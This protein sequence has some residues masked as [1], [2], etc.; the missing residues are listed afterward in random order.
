MALCR[1]EIIHR[2][3][4]AGLVDGEEVFPMGQLLKAFAAGHPDFDYNLFFGNGLADLLPKEAWDQ[5]QALSAHLDRRACGRM[6]Y[7]LVVADVF[8]VV[9]IGVGNTD[10]I[11]AF[12]DGIQNIKGPGR[13]GDS[14]DDFRL[15][16]GDRFHSKIS[17]FIVCEISVI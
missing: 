10:F 5:V 6:A 14:I 12:G 15:N 11:Q 9:K 13:G 1:Y 2:A 3:H 8:D 4:L 16:D 7:R 17:F